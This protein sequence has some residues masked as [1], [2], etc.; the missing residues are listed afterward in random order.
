MNRTALQRR[1][2]VNDAANPDF[3]SSAIENTMIVEHS[4]APEVERAK[5]TFESALQDLLRLC[6]QQLRDETGRDLLPAGGPGPVEAFAMIGQR[7]N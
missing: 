4:D 3:F 7:D 2:P 5:A 6:S 1:L